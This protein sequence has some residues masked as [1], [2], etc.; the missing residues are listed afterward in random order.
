M[1]IKEASQR[2]IIEQQFVQI[3]N[4]QKVTYRLKDELYH[5]VNDLISLS[6]INSQLAGD[7][8]PLGA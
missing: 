5:L 3:A 8:G 7:R 6:S 1:K 4:L 2:E